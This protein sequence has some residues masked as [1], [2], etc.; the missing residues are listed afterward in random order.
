MGRKELE[1][2]VGVHPCSPNAQEAEVAR[3]HVCLLLKNTVVYYIPCST[4]WTQDESAIVY[5]RNQMDMTPA[6]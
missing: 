5:S 6:F 4:N 2:G 1:L 3:S